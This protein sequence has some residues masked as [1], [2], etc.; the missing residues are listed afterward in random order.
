[1]RSASTHASGQKLPSCHGGNPRVGGLG[2]SVGC[3]VCDSLKAAYLQVMRSTFAPC[4]STTGK[5]V[6]MRPEWL[7]EVKYDGYRL[8]AGGQA[9]SADHAQRS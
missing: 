1:M 9:G 2:T 8:I 6:P 7:H 4:L 3:L 5:I